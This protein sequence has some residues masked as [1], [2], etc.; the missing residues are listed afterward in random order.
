MSRFSL[1][2][3]V[4]MVVVVPACTESARDA[5]PKEPAPASLDGTA[6][7]R[8]VSEVVAV[9]SNL[10]YYAVDDHDRLIVEVIDPV[11]SREV[12]QVE[13]VLPQ[14]P[15]GVELELGGDGESV[16]VLTDGRTAGRTMLERVGPTGQ[17][18]WSVPIDEPRSAPRTCDGDVCTVTSSGV[19]VRDATTGELT[20]RFG[21]DDGLQVVGVERDA[22]LA[23]ALGPRSSV[24]ALGVAASTVTAS[25]T[26]S[27]RSL[28]RSASVTSLGGWSAVKSDGVW[29]LWLGS[30]LVPAGIEITYPAHRG[31]GAIAGIHAEDGTSAW[32]RADVAPC[33]PIFD[34][35]TSDDQRTF[36]AC[37]GQL[38]Y[39]A[40]GVAPTHL[41][42][43]LEAVGLG[44]GRT[45]RTVRLDH[46]LDL[47]HQDGRV[48]RVAPS[49]WRVLD[50]STWKTFS[51]DTVA[52]PATG[53]AVGWCR[54]D[55]V[56]AQVSVVDRDG[57]TMAFPAIQTEVPCE[58]GPD[59]ATA[60]T[61]AQ[62]RANRR[63]LAAARGGGSRWVTWLDDDGVL[64][65][66][67]P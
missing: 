35:P 33:G 66:F 41:V 52:E 1:A 21:I 36:A 60:L 25:W 28:Y 64:H 4:G 55:E 67:R 13:A 62:V 27:I 29:V 3:A 11:R 30:T 22:V 56:T 12:G 39:V 2:L 43:T 53:R 45:E 7:A 47:L 20:G 58:T 63:T 10:A 24:P 65:G 8:P 17:S 6:V 14:Q 54:G 44:S 18:E 31:R 16:F 38:D 9:G 48:V 23:V 49:V 32:L 5:T 42:S 59:G 40:E 57:Q 15:S 34:P 37:D 61:S 46:P 19:E 51:L 50:G 26:Q